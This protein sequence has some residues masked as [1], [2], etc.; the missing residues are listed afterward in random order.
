M[1][2]IVVFLFLTSIFSVLVWQIGNKP[3]GT[4]FSAKATSTLYPS[5]Y[6]QS[7]GFDST[8]FVRIDSI[9]KAAI[10]GKVFPGCQVL[11]VKD[12][13]PI[14]NKCF[15]KYTYEGTQKVQANTMYDLASVSKIM[16]TLLAI[17]K[18]YDLGNLKL[19]DKASAYLPF[20]QNTDKENITV[21]E[22]LVHES[23]LPASLPFHRL[24]IE[25]NGSSTL[26]YKSDYV[27][28]VRTNEF[29]LQACDSLFIHNRIHN[30]AMQMIAN[31]R[32]NSKTYVYSCVNFILLKEIVEIISGMPMDEFLNK[33]FY[34]PMG[35]QHTAY[36]PLR[37]HKKEEITPT[38]QRDY[39]RK[40]LIQGYVHD[41]DA[42]FL[43]G[44]TGNA[45]LF[46]SASDVAKI[47]QMLLNN[48]EYEGKRYLSAATCQTFTTTTSASG[49]RG[50]GFDKPTPANSKYN[51]CCAS[52][53]L[54]VY[55]HTGYTGTCCWVDPI[56]KLV[57][58]FLSNRTYPNDGENKLAKWGIRTKIQ[59]V[60]Y[61]SI[62]KSPK[63]Q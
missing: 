61:D 40:T 53:P 63:N 4:L 59:E 18:L 26:V 17:M 38:L 30:E 55:G 2:K 58:V 52:A 54:E 20:L 24:A 1:K 50:L 22:L 60:I 21:T 9:V 57:Y 51:P 31:T 25:K 42:A 12:G 23:G 8:H 14:Y 5:L 37:S 33:K 47:H 19:N 15:G 56:N 43:G 27:S 32:L 48:G 45:G 36:L 34:Q 41:P 28:K 6:N 49:R 7:K 62:I 39:L 10:A 44:V 11:I 29:S 3:F 35:L 13:I 46:A 16:G